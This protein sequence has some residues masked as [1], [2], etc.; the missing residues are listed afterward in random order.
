MCWLAICLAVIVFDL[1]VSRIASAL[2]NQC[3]SDFCEC[4]RHDATSDMRGC[5]CG[6][7]NG[8]HTDL[9]FAQP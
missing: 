5:G 3:L 9:P 2:S 6:S 1:V 8:E 7:R 4:V